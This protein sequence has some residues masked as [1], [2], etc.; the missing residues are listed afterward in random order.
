MPVA[1]DKQG[2]ALRLE[3]DQWVPAQ[4]AT[5]PQTGETLVLDGDEWVTAAKP[6]R[7]P[8]QA[9]GDVVNQLGQGVMF[10]HADEAKAHVQ[11]F[12][13]DTLG[14]YEDFE[15]GYPERRAAIEGRMQSFERDYPK[16]S[17]AL[18]AGGGVA[19]ALAAPGGAAAVAPNALAR[20]RAT[21]S[22]MPTLAKW[23]GGGAVA[24]GVAGAGY[25]QPGER[26]EGAKT[27]AA[28]GGLLGI[29]I[30]G[31]ITALREGGKRAIR[32]VIDRIGNGA[33]SGAVRRV[34]R[35]LERDEMSVDDAIVRLDDL[36]DEATLA[37]VSPNMTGLA[38]SAAQRPGVAHSR[39]TDV[40]ENRR[41]GQVNRVLQLFDDAIGP[42]GQE[43]IENI[44]E[45]PA[46][47]DALR[48]HIPVTDDLV[49]FIN[50]PSLG[51]AW[52]RARKLAEE[53]DYV[54]PS[55]EEFVRRVEAGEITGIETTVLHWLKKGLDDVIEP[56]RNA[57]GVL[58]SQYGKNELAA[59][60]G[61]RRAFRELVK[62]ANP[63]YGASLDRIS[64]NKRIDDAYRRGM[65][66]F[67]KLKSP[68][69][70]SQLIKNFSPEERRA[71]QR[72]VR[73]MVENRISDQGALGYDTT[74]FPLGQGRKLEAVFG[75][76]LIDGLKTE[77]QLAQN[78]N[79]ILRGSQTGFRRAAEED[80]AIDPNIAIP[81]V[82]GDV[83]GAGVGLLRS[84]VNALNRPPQGVSDQ[85]GPIMFDMS[86]P[87]QIAGLLG[88][89]A[90]INA[91][92]KALNDK[93][94]MG[95]LA[96]EGQQSGRAQS[97]Y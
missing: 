32:P 4:K 3:G 57:V 72:G 38:E 63:D 48:H 69:Q 89:R 80:M 14:L 18:Q 35:A 30:P 55:R 26:M 42:T 39:A 81:M 7:T 1:V 17:L 78:E 34:L 79:R 62:E 43:V 86:A 66:E 16:T 8:L 65:E 76:D 49:R 13:N 61:T 85:L 20:A 11:Q 33:E 77:R 71:Y 51:K 47:Q 95:L 84:G 5:N 91:S 50:R 15:G 92:R 90:Q 58:E 96:I 94:M 12:L 54:L 46:F 44:E 29:G 6:D 19:T 22:Q 83:A 59:M 53:G 31:V 24:G 36:G 93:A 23:F 28:V 88:H 67:T 64:R 60:Q 87:A 73:D 10:G 27:G 41:G 40:L 70:V 68:D 82:Q 21:I 74:R 75:G 25:S 37:D 97:G 45:S 56:K 9:A 2:N 52:Q